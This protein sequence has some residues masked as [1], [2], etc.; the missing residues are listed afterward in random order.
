MPAAPT[1]PVLQVEESASTQA[2]PNLE[3]LQGSTHPHPGPRTGEAQ[4]AQAGT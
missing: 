1:V 3:G 2:G 4:Q